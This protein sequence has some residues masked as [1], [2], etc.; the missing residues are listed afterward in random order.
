MSPTPD[1]TPIRLNPNRTEPTAR[2]AGCPVCG[3]SKSD[4][5]GLLE[6]HDKYGY[7]KVSCLACCLTDHRRDDAR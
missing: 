1:E 6:A 5:L 4:F 3:K 2:V 7:A